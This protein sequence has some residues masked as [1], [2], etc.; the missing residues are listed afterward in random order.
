MAVAARRQVVTSPQGWMTLNRERITP[1]AKD[2]LRVT[3]NYRVGA[4]GFLYLGDGSL[5][6]AS[7]TRSP[8]SDG[9]RRTSGPW[10]E[11]TGKV[12]VCGQSAG[13]MSVATLPSVLRAKGL[14]HRVPSSKG[15]QA[16]TSRHPRRR[17]GLAGGSQRRWASRGR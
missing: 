1:L 13:A 2:S 8:R 12:T 6:R 16:V 15:G 4:E 17:S 10:A 14:F 7:S 5:T 11:T 3:I 9:C